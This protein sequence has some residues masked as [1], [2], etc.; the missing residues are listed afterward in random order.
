MTTTSLSSSGKKRFRSRLY[1]RNNE[2]FCSAQ[3]ALLSSQ[4][5]RT[6][7]SLASFGNWLGSK[8]FAGNWT[9]AGVSLTECSA[10]TKKKKDYKLEFLVH[11]H[12]D[13]IRH[14]TGSQKKQRLGHLQRSFISPTPRGAKP[15]TIK[16]FLLF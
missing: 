6:T 9:V 14:N 4:A 8:I 2:S 11:F 13:G 5:S 12:H 15:S 7:W 16:K 10:I 1:V 3:N